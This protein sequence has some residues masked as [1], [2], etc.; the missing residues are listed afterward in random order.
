M[1]D[2]QVHRGGG[3]VDVTVKT[4]AYAP[5]ERWLD[6]DDCGELQCQTYADLI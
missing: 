3:T 1:I 2:L 5:G 6:Y 4:K